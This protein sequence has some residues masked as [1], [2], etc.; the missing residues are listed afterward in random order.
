[1]PKLDPTQKYQHDVPQENLAHTPRPVDRAFPNT[2]VVCRK[3]IH[4]VDDNDGPESLKAL[5]RF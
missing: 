3:R 4:K 1:M 5:F 2:C